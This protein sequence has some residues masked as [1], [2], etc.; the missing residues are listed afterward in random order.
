MKKILLQHRIGWRWHE[1]MM[2]LIMARVNIDISDD[3]LKE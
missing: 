2:T 3:E 1:E